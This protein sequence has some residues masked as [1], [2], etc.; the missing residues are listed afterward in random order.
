MFIKN[1]YRVL[2]TRARE[3]IVIFIP[4]GDVKDETRLP[5]FYDPIFEYLESCGM[6]VISELDNKKNWFIQLLIW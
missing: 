3:G 5:K 1:T 4:K 2:L 6:D